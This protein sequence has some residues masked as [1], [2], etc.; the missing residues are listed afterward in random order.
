[1]KRDFPA[2]TE[3]EGACEPC[4]ERYRGIMKGARFTPAALSTVWIPV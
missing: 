3:Q 2:W 4:L 1:M